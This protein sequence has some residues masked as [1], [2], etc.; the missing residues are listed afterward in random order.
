MDNLEEKLTGLLRDPE[1]M[2]KIMT[3]AQSIGKQDTEKP[4]PSPQNNLPQIDPNLLTSLSGF[5]GNN[6]VNQEEQALLKALTPYLSHHRV[7]KLER[8]MRA[9]RMAK[10]ASAFLNAGGMQMLTGR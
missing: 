10:F 8:A 3:M 4:S 5:L 1:A 9:A 2:Q 6:N 7:S